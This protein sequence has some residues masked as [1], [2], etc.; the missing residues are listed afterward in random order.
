VRAAAPPGA[1]FFGETETRWVQSTMVRV[2]WQGRSFAT[3]PP[4]CPRRKGPS[5]R[6]CPTGC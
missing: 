1:L 4:L 2:R 5:R 6:G 3:A